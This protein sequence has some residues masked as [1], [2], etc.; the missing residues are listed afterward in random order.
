MEY[1]TLTAEYDAALAALIRTNLKAH[2]L[3]IP[4]TVYFDDGLDHLSVFYDHE[5]RSYFVLLDGK[6]LVGG[7]GLLSGAGVY[8]QE[9]RYHHGRR[10]ECGRRIGCCCLYDGNRWLTRDEIEQLSISHK[11]TSIQMRGVKGGRAK[12]PWAFTE[13]GIYMLLTGMGGTK[14]AW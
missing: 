2:H 1:R 11:V 12:L 7:I 13:S 10:R 3:D 9:E 8:E 4:G 14:D 6:N 5:G